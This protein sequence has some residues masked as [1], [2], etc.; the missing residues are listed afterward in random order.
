M[1]EPNYYDVLGVRPNANLESIKNAYREKV[2]EYHPDTLTGELARRRNAGNY[3]GAY[4]IERRIEQYR[5]KTQDINAAYRIL[6]DP[7]ERAAY[8][9]RR[10]PARS[11]SPSAVPSNDGR[12]GP[13]ADRRAEAFHPKP[14]PNVEE[15]LPVRWV[16]GLVIFLVIIFSTFVSTFAGV[17]FGDSIKPAG[18][19]G[20]IS[21]RALQATQNA[22]QATIVY[23]TQIALTP[24]ST[25]RSPQDNA[26]A[27][28]A[29]LAR[30]NA[31]IAEELFTKAL[32]G[33]PNA[34]W[35][36]LRGQA[37][38]ALAQ[39]TPTYY[40]GALAD[41][42]QALALDTD[43]PQAYYGRMLARFAL[44]QAHPSEDARLA[45]L[46]DLESYLARTDDRDNPQVRQILAQIGE[47]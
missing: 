5:K 26:E 2:R 15:K 35:Y 25:P 11:A 6:S 7:H 23:I 36:L 18:S 28:A 37:R 31:K 4:E 22:E 27:G 8:D 17:L 43:D 30:G 42:T 34:A 39:T 19:S 45:V 46:S 21:A 3:G 44:W 47:R 29:F 14:K 32:A 9:R 10:L 33:Q 16:V 38:L 12:T 40:D 1:S 13:Y 24:T 41:F 20:G